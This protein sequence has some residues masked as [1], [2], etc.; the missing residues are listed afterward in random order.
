M[1]INKR[2]T[3]M[4]FELISAQSYV[5]YESLENNFEVTQR[6]IRED[7]KCLNDLLDK[8]Y[9][10]KIQYQSGR[11]FF[12]ACEND[13]YLEKLKTQL[14]MRFSDLWEI[15]DSMED[16]YYRI[17]AYFFTRQGYG[18][19]DELSHLLNLNPRSISNLLKEA[20][21]KLSRYQLSILVRPHY[22]MMLSG[23]ETHARYCIMD[24]IY[25]YSSELKGS[26]NDETLEMFK[27]SGD[28][29]RA[30]FSLCVEYIDETQT[31]L[32]QTAVHKLILLIMISSPN[33][34]LL[35]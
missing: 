21:R 29:K 14:S 17:V 35:L 19:M 18:K 26:S 28:E 12:L 10:V 30:L 6:T 9:H 4:L 2:Q 15:E 20:R 31:A 24:I 11:G 3:S 34:Y 8:E 23:R 25:R 22:G 32:S 13:H 7:I 27:L 5:S 1:K 33:K 16:N